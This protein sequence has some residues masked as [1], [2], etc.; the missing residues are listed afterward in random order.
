M[1]DGSII[2]TSIFLFHSLYFKKTRFIL[3]FLLVFYGNKQKREREREGRETECLRVGFFSRLRSRKNFL[4]FFFFFEE[5]E[6]V[7]EFE[8]GR[9]HV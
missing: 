2:R 1:S 9:A 7:A 8:I 4:P 6:R 3:I 5:R